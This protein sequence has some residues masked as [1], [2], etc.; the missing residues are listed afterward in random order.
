MN[1][2]LVNE[3]FA[4]ENGPFIDGLPIKNGDFPWLCLFTRGYIY[5]CIYI[6][7]YIDNGKLIILI[8][9]IIM[10]IM[11]A[12]NNNIYNSNNDDMVIFK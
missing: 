5:I 1:Y 6:D 8:I 3:Q 9:M 4:M 10:V 11:M 12:I 7:R 2:P